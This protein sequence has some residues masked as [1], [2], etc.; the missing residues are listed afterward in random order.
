MLRN[1]KAL[2]VDMRWFGLIPGVVFCR[3]SFVGGPGLSML[4]PIPN[5]PYEFFYQSS[6]I[7]RE[8]FP[9]N[10]SAHG[11]HALVFVS[12]FGEMPQTA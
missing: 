2:R 3:F 11:E 6:C 10:G 12:A 5:R 9:P 7:P 1:P 8:I 4:L